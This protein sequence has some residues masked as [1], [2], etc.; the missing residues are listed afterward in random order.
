MISIQV[1]KLP[2]EQEYY[3]QPYRVHWKSIPDAPLTAL[4]NIILPSPQFF[5]ENVTASTQFMDAKLSDTQYRTSKTCLSSTGK[6][7]AWFH[8][9]S[10][11]EK[12]LFLTS[13]T[14]TSADHLSRFCRTAYPP[15][16]WDSHRVL[17]VTS[18]T[19]RAR[20]SGGK[21]QVRSYRW[22]RLST[23]HRVS[24][25]VCWTNQAATYT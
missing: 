18:D 24:V 20:R 25:R 22:E 12:G 23:V 10:A 21:N 16:D 1:L 3:T 14:T 19:A 17:K 7:A 15:S 9:P 6:M 5:R 13:I 4:C 8:S 11:A 2:N